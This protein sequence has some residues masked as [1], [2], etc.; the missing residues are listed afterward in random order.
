MAP[1][2]GDYEAQANRCGRKWTKRSA[3]CAFAQL[4]AKERWFN[5]H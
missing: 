4:G 1:T 2:S 3:N 5:L